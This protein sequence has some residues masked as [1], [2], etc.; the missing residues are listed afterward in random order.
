MFKHSDDRAE[1]KGLEFGEV[2][3]NQL[4][5]GMF[6]V[7]PLPDPEFLRR[8]T[9]VGS[10]LRILQHEMPSACVSLFLRNDAGRLGRFV[11]LDIETCLQ[12]IPHSPLAGRGSR[13]AVRPP[14]R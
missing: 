8:E 11:L 9:R 7:Q 1:G 5:H 14:V 10:R 12:G 13:K 6:A 2:V 4:L 3:Q